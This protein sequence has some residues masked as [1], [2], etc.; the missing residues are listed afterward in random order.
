VLHEFG[1]GAEVI[2]FCDGP[3]VLRRSLADLLP[4]AFGLTSFPVS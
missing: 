4:A 3:E 2:A 1:P